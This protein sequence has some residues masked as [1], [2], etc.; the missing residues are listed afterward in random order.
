MLTRVE[1]ES[2]AVEE[3]RDTVDTFR[4]NSNMKGK[5]YRWYTVEPRGPRR[6]A[7]IE[8]MI[9]IDVYYHQGIVEERMRVEKW[10]PSSVT[11]TRVAEEHEP[12]SP[13]QVHELNDQILRRLRDGSNAQ[14]AQRQLQEVLDAMHV[15]PTN[16]PRTEPH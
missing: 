5:R 13:E 3:Y 6:V 9:I 14:R 4:F 1:T 16:G 15:D 12:E 11:V 10:Y 2:G 8:R 7:V